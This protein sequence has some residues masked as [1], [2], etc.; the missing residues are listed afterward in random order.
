[1]FKGN[2]NRKLGIP[3]LGW[4]RIERLQLFGWNV[5]GK[6]HVAFETY[7]Y[8]YKGNIFMGVSK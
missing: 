4:I 7:I 3:L 5:A 2:G 8:I 6:L 1:M